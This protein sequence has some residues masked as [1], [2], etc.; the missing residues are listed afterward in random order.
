MKRLLA[1]LIF[2]CLSFFGCSSKDV[3][4]N[5]IVQFI[6]EHATED[7]NQFKHYTIAIR[8]NNMF[9]TIYLV[10]DSDSNI[11]K[12]ICFVT[13][14]KFSGNIEDVDIKSDSD[15]ITVIKGLINRY[16][17]YNYPYLSVD[18]DSNV[19]INPFYV[20]MKPYFLFYKS[21]NGPKKIKSNFAVFKHYQGNCYINNRY[22]SN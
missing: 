5:D 19:Y 9:E 8:Q 22:L 4:S 16:Q 12:P 15:K 18:K 13:V 3:S 2:A 21:G 6:N 17:S 11:D 10:S 1:M 20:D 14:N 7:F